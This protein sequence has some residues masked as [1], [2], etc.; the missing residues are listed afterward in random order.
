MGGNNAPIMVNGGNVYD[1]PL[2]YDAPVDY[3]TAQVNMQAIGTDWSLKKCRQEVIRRLGFVV[4]PVKVQRTFAQLRSTVAT[5][6]G[7]S[8]VAVPAPRTMESLRLELL[9]R[10]GFSAQ[11]DMG[12]WSPGMKELLT[13]FL[14]EA[15]VALQHQYR[16]SVDTPLA[17]FQADADVTTLD[18][19]A[20]FLLALANAKAHH[21]QTDSKAYFEQ[22]G[23]YI[24]TAAKSA[25]IDQI[26]NSAQDSLLQR[27]AMDRYTDGSAPLV[28][29][30][31][32]TLID[33]VAVEAQAVADAKA[34]YGQKDAE[35]YYAR[36]KE[37]AQRRPFDLDAMVDSF[38]RD[39]QDQLYQQYKELRTERWWTIQCV[40]GANLY[41]VPL[42]LD[43]YLDFRRITWAGIQ[44]DVQ[45]SP[46]IEGIDPLLYTSNSLSKPAYFR[47]TGCI[48]IYPAPDRAYTI[49]IRGHLGLKWLNGDDDLLTVNSRAVFLHS[50][51]N[52]KAHYQQPD[53]GNYMQQAQAYVRQLIA[54]SHGTRRYIPGTRQV[55]AAR[56]PIPVGGW[57]ENH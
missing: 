8:H 33:G 25:D 30:G 2:G 4:E 38:I 20:V 23:G 27:Y 28:G 19:W 47:V 16:L 7:F 43:Q 41:D 44:D 12:F 46:M 10:L 11:A 42:D 57:P 3:D 34:K 24:A 15:Q 50:L 39:A 5:A 37:M 18:P 52:A 54:G 36:L 17:P 21:G 32:K 56:R 26:I 1:S 29:G 35:A 49:K 40:P 48:E 9:R 55:P 6:L 31:D 51:A 45:W 53:A 22:L 13:N 14:Y